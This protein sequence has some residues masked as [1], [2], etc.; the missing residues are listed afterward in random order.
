MA[1]VADLFGGTRLQDRA[2]KRQDGGAQILRAIRTEHPQLADRIFTQL[3]QDHPNMDLA[4]GVRRGELDQIKATI[5]AVVADDAHLK[6]LTPQGLGMASDANDSGRLTGDVHAVFNATA[7][8]ATKDYMDDNI[9]D[10]NDPKVHKPHVQ[11]GFPTV[12][13]LERAHG[14]EV[15]Q[16]AYLLHQRLHP[17]GRHSAPPAGRSCSWSITRWRTWPRATSRNGSATS[18][19]SCRPGGKS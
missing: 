16:R 13:A 15:G 6:S 9:R 7:R 5:D 1:K 12:V 18:S 4:R 3:G 17:V 11:T 14:V 8:Q 10:L 2:Q 19:G